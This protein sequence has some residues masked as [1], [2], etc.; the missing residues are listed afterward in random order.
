MLLGGVEPH[1]LVVEMGG[2]WIMMLAGYI[3]HVQLGA[4]I[5]SRSLALSIVRMVYSSTGMVIHWRS[6][7]GLVSVAQRLSPH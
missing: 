6:R 3:N 7:L 1:Y 2:T 4:A 5:E